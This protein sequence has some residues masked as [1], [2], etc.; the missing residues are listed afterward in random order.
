[1]AASGDGDPGPAWVETC[2]IA[3]TGT[4]ADYRSHREAVGELKFIA[5][6]A[7]CRQ[8]LL[9]EIKRG[10]HCGKLNECLFR[11]LVNV[12]D[13]LDFYWSFHS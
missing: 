8:I 1:M 4:E 10:I 6:K 7:V 5:V 12:L 13:V 9:P 2:A 11:K 3:W